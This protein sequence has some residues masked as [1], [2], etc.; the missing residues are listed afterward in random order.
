MWNLIAAFLA[1]MVFMTLIG[2]IIKMDAGQM[3]QR[4]LSSRSLSS[5]A[6]LH[7]YISAAEAYIATNPTIVS[8]HTPTNPVEI[9]Y[10]DAQAAG[11]NGGKTNYWGQPI[12]AYSWASPDSSYPPPVYAFF[13]GQPQSGALSQAGLAN[14]T[15]DLEGIATSMSNAY[16]ANFAGRM[17]Q[18]AVL[19]G[20]TAEAAGD[21]FT[22]TM[23]GGVYDQTP[24]G[25]ALGNFKLGEGY[26]GGSTIPPIGGGGGGG[27]P[28]SGCKGTAPG[29]GYQCCP[30]RWYPDYNPATHQPILCP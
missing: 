1:I 9:P 19:T 10:A 8:G 25:G 29:P 14:T 15:A 30:P 5:A 26:G 23:G 13:E 7:D 20:N 22:Y 17:E 27:G 11:Y 24:T 28:K 12:T 4:T 2:L 3:H 18:P 6:E 21:A 16:L